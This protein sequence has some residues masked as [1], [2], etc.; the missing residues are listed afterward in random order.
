M[1]DF[2]KTILP[3]LGAAATGGV[4]AL[5]GMAAKTVGDAIGKDVKSTADA[6][7]TAVAGATPEQM[8]ALKKA[9]QDFALQMQS[10][11]FDHERQLEQIAQ[12]DRASARQREMTV[13]DYTPSVLAACVIV[14]WAFVQYIL[15]TTVIEASMRELVSR[16]LGTLDAALMAVL[17]YY[18][19]SSSSSAHKNTIISKF[20]DNK[21][22]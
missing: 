5:I 21:P 13:K 20:N 12:T 4:P 14:A 11:G 10:L 7:A 1:N 9:D 3:W 18:F 8:I 15:L 17:Y 6:I 22:T 2:F 16:M 19:G